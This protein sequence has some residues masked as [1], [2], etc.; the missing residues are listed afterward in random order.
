MHLPGHFLLAKNRAA[1]L[2]ALDRLLIPRR[3]QDG[4][5]TSR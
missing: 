1:T 5:S 3:G 4:C 2:K